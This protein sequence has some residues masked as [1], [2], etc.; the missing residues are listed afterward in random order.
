VAS[1][2]RTDSKVRR[3]IRAIV[4]IDPNDPNNRYKII[5]WNENVPN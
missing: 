1:G 3:I 4:K 2:H 5:Y